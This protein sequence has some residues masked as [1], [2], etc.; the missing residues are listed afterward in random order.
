MTCKDCI[1]QEACAQFIKNDGDDDVSN[2][3]CFTP[4]SEWVYLPLKVGDKVYCFEPDFE[5]ES[6]P[7]LQVVE[8]KILNIQTFLHVCGGMYEIRNVG[9]S[10]FFTQ[11]EA[12]KELDKKSKQYG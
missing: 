11:E 1:H 6:R 7:K 2:W 9:E 4:I 12:E 5:A 10:V 8:R 3:K